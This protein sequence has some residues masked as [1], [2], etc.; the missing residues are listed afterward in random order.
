MLAM[1]LTSPSHCLGGRS[2]S[3]LHI[4]A[5]EA[6]MLRD[7]LLQSHHPLLIACRISLILLRLPSQELI[8][9]VR[10]KALV[11]DTKTLAVPRNLL[12]VP[13]HI[14]QILREVRE[15]PLKDL[16][17][18]LSSHSGLEVRVLR[19]S[20]LWV[21][22]DEVC[23]LFNRP[24][25]SADFVRV[26]GY[27][28]LV[29]DVENRAEAA[30]AQLGQLIDPHHLDVGLGTAL[31]GKPLGKLNHLHVLEADAGIDFAFDDGFGDVHAA[32]DSGIVSGCH[33]V[34]GCKL[35]DLDLVR[36]A[37]ATC[38][39]TR[40]WSYLAELAHVTDLLAL[41]RTEV[42]CD[43]A[44]L[45]IDDAGEGLVQERA[46]RQDREVAGFRLHLCKS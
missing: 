38:H 27:E 19:P 30:A 3:T 10:L 6:A 35:I 31:R 33:A 37:D 4:Q 20:L 44:V 2:D 15:A 8:R 32:A 45:Q 29:A 9:V 16:A 34:V 18:Q 46:N 23:S 24:H 14:F 26:F 36:L 1:F 12:P 25:E 21:A 39:G 22:Q 7:V 28:L 13:G 42:G 11:K 41:Q 5:L 40:R 43:A 17:V